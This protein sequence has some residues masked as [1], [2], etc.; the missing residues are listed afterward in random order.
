MVVI[1][2]GEIK[3]VGEESDN[4]HGIPQLKDG[5]DDCIEGSMGGELLVA[6]HTLSV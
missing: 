2:H 5:S 4:D 3:T 1:E 6:R